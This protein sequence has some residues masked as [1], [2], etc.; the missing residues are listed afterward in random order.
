MTRVKAVQAHK[1]SVYDRCWYRDVSDSVGGQQQQ[2]RHSLT[3]AHQRSTDGQPGLA[4]ARGGARSA[5]EDSGSLL[6]IRSVVGQPG[7]SP[8]TPVAQL[9]GSK[10]VVQTKDGDHQRGIP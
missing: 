8:H 6:S 10:T 5:E 4:A 3:A 9:P 2:L 1:E 7:P